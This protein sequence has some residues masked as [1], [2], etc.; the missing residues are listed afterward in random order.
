MGWY[1][2]LKDAIVLASRL[3]DTELEQKLGALQM[4]C[5]A[6]AHE[7]SLLREE[8]NKLKKRLDTREAMKY[9]QNVYW[10][11]EG[12]DRDGPFCPNCLSSEDRVGPLQDRPDEHYGRCHVCDK[13]VAKPGQ[14]PK[15]AGLGR[16]RGRSAMS[17]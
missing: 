15:M 11:G 5:G 2:P 8:C 7:N 1:E 6:L 12:D 4:E 17:S 3:K 14:D 16:T 13:K 9:E 10:M